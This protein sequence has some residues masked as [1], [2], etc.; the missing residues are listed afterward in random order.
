MN[1]KIGT[2]TPSRQQLALLAKAKHTEEPNGRYHALRQV[3]TDDDLTSGREELHPE[4]L[5]IYESLVDVL[6]QLPSGDEIRKALHNLSV[7]EGEIKLIDPKAGSIAFLLGAGASKPM[8]SGIPTVAELLP[9][10]LARGRRLE[11]EDVNR[12]A[13]FCDNSK[14]TNIEDLLTAAHLSRYCGQNPTVLRLIEFLLYRESREDP[15]EDPRFGQIARSRVDTGSV[16]FLQDTL[17]VLFGLLS[18]RMLPAKPNAAHKAIAVYAKENVG[19]TVIT[20]NYDCCID[21]ALGTN[22]KDFDYRMP[23]SNAKN[24]STDAIPNLIKL[25][26]SLNWFYCDSCQKVNLID[27]D[28]AILDFETDGSPYPIIGV[29]RICGGQRRGLLVPPQAMKFDVASA[30]NPLLEIANERLSNAAVLAVVGFSFAE[31]DMYISRMV[32]RWM[33]SDINR[34]LVIF[35]PNVSVA[36]KM[37][38]QCALR[39]AEFDDSRVVWKGGDSAENIPKFLSGQLFDPTP[40]EMEGTK[41]RGIKR[42]A[43]DPHS[44][45]SR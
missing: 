29:C 10:L 18:S 27:I 22:G 24:V 7:F 23:F 40:P 1:L 5:S 37:R 17:Q 36:D 38:K 2:S 8:P 41:K 43:G 32:S 14:I 13:D 34:R 21:L 33:Q 4:W 45:V 15:R 44:K 31:A 35:D 16:A 20:T 42:K 6:P 19:T 25:H 26:G 3:V 12:L 39:I 9:D 28:K 30:L 11:R